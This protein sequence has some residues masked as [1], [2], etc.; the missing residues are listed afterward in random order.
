MVAP[1]VK[2]LNNHA[3]TLLYISIIHAFLIQMSG[4]K[5]ELDYRRQLGSGCDTN[6]HT[7]W[8]PS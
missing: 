8:T 5:N 1:L 7:T 2:V 3:A 6:G 4:T